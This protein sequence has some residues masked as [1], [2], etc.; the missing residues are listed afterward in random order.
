MDDGQATQTPP[1]RRPLPRG[2]GKRAAR[3]V[4]EASLHA[5]CH[6]NGFSWEGGHLLD[7]KSWN[8]RRRATYVRG[9][10]LPAADWVWHVED[11]ALHDLINQKDPRDHRYKELQAYLRSRGVGLTRLSARFVRVYILCKRER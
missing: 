7:R 11:E 5:W 9:Q 2:M 6:A 4:I 8:A 3:A 10:S 1:P